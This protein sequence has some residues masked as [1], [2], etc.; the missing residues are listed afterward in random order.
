MISPKKPYCIFTGDTLLIGDTGKPDANQQSDINL[1]NKQLYASLQKL[2]KLPA[3]IILYPTHSQNHHCGPKVKEQR[4]SSTLKEAIELA[5]NIKLSEND[6]IAQ[7]KPQPGFPYMKE[8]VQINLQKVAKFNDLLSQC[9]IPLSLQ[10][11]ESKKKTTFVLDT[12]KKEHFME[13]SIPGT[14]SVN[15]YTMNSE[16]WAPRMVPPKQKILL[17]T[18]PNNELEA[19][20]RLLRIGIDQI[21]GFLIGGIETWKS[22]N[23]IIKGQYIQANT[24][25]DDDLKGKFIIDVRNP[26]EFAEGHIIGAASHPLPQLEESLKK[27]NNL[28]PRD[29]DIQVICLGGDR[30]TISTSILRNFGYTRIINYMGGYE[31][32]KEKNNLTIV[33]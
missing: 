11:F 24:L 23:P 17:I 10:E 22:K 18:E 9:L 21:Q 6:F 15:I 32:I 2:I 19:V 14:I 28:F 1:A 29:Q 13:E 8:L 12:R 33:K 4:V 7:V 20:T 31:S 16:L 26:P 30:A 3:D 5:P 25:K 27:N